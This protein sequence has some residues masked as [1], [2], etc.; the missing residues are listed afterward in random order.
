MMEKDKFIKLLSRRLSGT[1]ST[2]EDQ[3]LTDAL[4][5]NDKYRRIFDEVVSYTKV[6]KPEVSTSQSLALVWQQIETNGNT[7]HHRFDFT[8]PQKTGLKHNKFFKAAAILLLISAIGITGLRLWNKNEEY[9]TFSTTNHKIFKVLQDGTKVWLNKKSKIRLNTAFGDK[10]REITLEGEAYFDVVKNQRVPLKIQTGHLQIEVKGTAFN[11]NA[12][13]ASA[14]TEVSLVRGSIEVTDK[15]NPENK[16]LLK[17]NEKLTIP[18]ESKSKKNVFNIVLVPSS[19]LLRDTKW[20]VDTLVFKKEKLK[21]L[22]I[23]LAHKYDLKIDIRSAKLKETRFSGAFTTETI[24]QALEALKL[25]YPF[26]Y[27]ISNR[28]VLIND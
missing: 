14:K 9:L 18:N 26:T 24:Q 10:K 19:I 25:S 3:A 16:T 6:A 13:Q 27:T 21:D 17:P 22:V 11:V 12:Y 7:K 1:I 2:S 5:S 20:T 8:T 4:S 23:R 15:W 28:L